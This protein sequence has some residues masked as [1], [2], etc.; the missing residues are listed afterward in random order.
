MRVYCVFFVLNGMTMV[1]RQVFAQ[2]LELKFVTLNGN[3]QVFPAF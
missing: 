3:E 2:N 1:V